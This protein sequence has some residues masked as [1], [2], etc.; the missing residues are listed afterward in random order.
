MLQDRLGVDEAQAR[1]L[2]NIAVACPVPGQGRQ[3]SL[4]EFMTSEHGADKADTIVDIA[5]QALERGASPE[6]AMAQALGFA[7]VRDR[8]TGELARVDPEESK[9]K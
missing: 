1:D 5:T 2:A 9:K 7:A 3:A 8:E 4:G 6:E